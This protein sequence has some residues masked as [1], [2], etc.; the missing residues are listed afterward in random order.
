MSLNH[1]Q[2]AY[3]AIISTLIF[4]ALFVG[5]SGFYQTSDGIGE[6]DSAAEED[7]FGDE[8]SSGEAADQDED[9]LPDVLESQYGTD[10]TDPDTDKDGMSDGWE[11]DHGLNPLDNG[12]S[13]LL[14]EETG[15]TT[16]ADDAEISN[17][18]DSWPDPE[19]GK[20]GDP[21][22]DG[23][24]N[25]QEAELGTDPQRADTD[26]DGLNDRWESL[27]GMNVSSPD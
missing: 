11:V 17:E 16:T 24:T 15:S 21:D 1:N 14:E 8:V 25:E 26:N 2:M 10:P 12:E 27:Y 9:G 6:F 19:Q 18:S 4:G 7:L 22:R 20:Y 5:V 3:A 13:E 23:L